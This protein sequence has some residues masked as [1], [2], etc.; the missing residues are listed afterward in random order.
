MSTMDRYSR[1]IL[2]S[3]IGEDGQSRLLKSR[4]T[5]LG[6]GALGTCISEHLTRAG[7][8]DILIIDRDFIELNNLQRQH[9]FSEGDV[10]EPKA[11]VAERKLKSINST[12]SIQG[13]VDDVNETN[14]QT[15]VQG[16]DVLVDGTDNLNARFLINDASVK[17]G[18]PW[19]H[20]ACV[21]VHG[22]V[23]G[24]SPQGPCLRCFLP[25]MPSPETIPSVD[26]IGIINTLPTV[27]GALES[28]K[29]IQ[30]LVTGHMES[31][32][33]IVDLWE[34]DFRKIIVTQRKDCPCCVHHTY[35]FLDESRKKATALVGRDAVQ[36]TPSSA[37]SIDLPTLAEHL[38]SQG[39]V[40]L[41]PHVLYFSTATIS[42]SLFPDGRAIIKG[43]NDE[44]EAQSLYANYV[45]CR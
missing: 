43:T 36:V 7:I 44:K 10:G 15:Y 37:G 27:I 31:E 13:V 42:M 20:G 24:I 38:K 33:L 40:N 34:Q 18:I 29:T 16:R 3:Q 9:L 21:S 11:L 28:T 5:V 25:Q 6:C 30:Y 32:L 17:W 26:T 19:V 14:I 22:Q 2:L 35:E 8:G 41:T 39:K 4:V 45:G 1:Q 12:I 23:M